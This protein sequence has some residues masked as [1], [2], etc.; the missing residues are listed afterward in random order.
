MIVITVTKVIL[1]QKL[2]EK[3]A[4][5]ETPSAHFITRDLSQ[6]E[7]LLHMQESLIQVVSSSVHFVPRSK[8]HMM[9][10]T[11]MKNHIHM[12][13]LDMNVQNVSQS[14]NLNSNFYHIH[15]STMMKKNTMFQVW[16][17]IHKFQCIVGTS[18]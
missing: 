7:K 4:L 8:K 10:N 6:K 2:K 11:N 1:V 12:K 18:R 15:G 17:K 3:S 13:I 5:N 14:F 9:G 16:P